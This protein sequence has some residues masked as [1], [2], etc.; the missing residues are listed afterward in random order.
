MFIFWGIP[1]N[2]CM[3]SLYNIEN[4]SDFL[5]LLLLSLNIND[6]EFSFSTPFIIIDKCTYLFYVYSL[7]G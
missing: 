2:K 7:L 4:L 5:D 6:F 3:D 1:D